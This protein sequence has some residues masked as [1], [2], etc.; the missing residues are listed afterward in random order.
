MNKN[1]EILV[2]D[3]VCTAAKDFADLIES[4]LGLQT[5]AEHDPDAVMR[6]I[7]EYDIK[8]AVIDQV[9]P[10]KIGN[11]LIQDIHAV[12]PDIKALLLTGEASEEQLGNAINVGFSKFLS[13]HNISRLHRDVYELYIKY[14]VET[15]NKYNLERPIR[16]KTFGIASYFLLSCDPIKG[17]RLDESKTT[18]LI[19]IFAGQEQEYEVNIEVNNSI[20]IDSEAEANLVSNL[21]I[22]DSIMKTLKSEV[23]TSI[24]SHYNVS[25]TKSNH[26]S[27]RSKQKISLPSQ[28]TDVEQVYVAR[29]LIECVP[30][31]QDYQVVIK[32]KCNWCK[33]SKIAMSIMSIQLNRFLLRETR[34]YS[35]GKVEMVSLGD[36]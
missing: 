33:T 18:K 12:K 23:N 22:S 29:K 19:E 6:I 3:D 1:P 8:V 15:L 27:N 36:Y 35:D 28:P 13:K 32:R 14:E 34:Y 30:Y 11:D 26:I 2:V 10:K 17:V 31:F 20:T 21:S 5:I 25:E 9:M 7:R 16:L 24:R 4:K